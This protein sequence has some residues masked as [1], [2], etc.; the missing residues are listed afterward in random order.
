MEYVGTLLSLCCSS[1]PSKSPIHKECFIL[2]VNACMCKLK[3]SYLTLC[4]LRDCSLPGYLSMG[5]SRQECWRGLP[6]P[7]PRDLLNP[8]LNLSLLH[9]LHWRAHSLPLCHLWRWLSQCSW[10]LPAELWPRT[11]DVPL[12]SRSGR[13]RRPANIHLADLRGIW[14]LEE[15]E[16]NTQAGSLEAIYFTL[17]TPELWSRYT[18]HLSVI[19]SHLSFHP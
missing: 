15:G 7:P 16:S 6:F 5:F 17:W 3:E 13:Q 11:H 10:I 9:L 1:P 2:C 8:G 4:N 18:D 19:T 14:G 12:F